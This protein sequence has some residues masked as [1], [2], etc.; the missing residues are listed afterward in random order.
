MPVP[1]WLTIHTKT[2]KEKVVRDY[3]QSLYPDVQEVFLPLINNIPLFP[4]YVFALLAIDVVGW[5]RL[6]YQLGIGKGVVMYGEDA[7]VIPGEVINAIKKS[8]LKS[9]KNEA[10]RYFQEGGMVTF[11]LGTDSIYF[12][13]IIKLKSEKALVSLQ[14]SKNNPVQLEIQLSELKLIPEKI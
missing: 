13:E 5:R 4:Q 14:L 11:N 3:L 6:T 8:D 10:N 7:A 12:G 1:E 9:S 2:N